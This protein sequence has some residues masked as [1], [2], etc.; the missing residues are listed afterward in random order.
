MRNYSR[1]SD[2]L[3]TNASLLHH[4]SLHPPI[5]T[6]VPPPSPP[7][8]LPLRSSVL[9]VWLHLFT[10]FLFTHLA[11]PPP[12]S[13]GDLFFSLC[14]GVSVG[15]VSFKSR[16]H[17]QIMRFSLLWV[18]V[19]HQT[20][21][22]EDF[23]PCFHEEGCEMALSSERSVKPILGQCN[24]RKIKYRS[25]FLKF[26]RLNILYYI[27]NMVGSLRIFNINEIKNK[28]SYIS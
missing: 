1:I 14:G 17:L 23:G 9:P 7:P 5:S 11:W 21:P 22:L 27:N 26:N 2:H 16:R 28:I 6:P 19:L 18:F 3:L 10:P 13:P 12:P 20:F 25:W 15:F 4:L 24:T 8:P